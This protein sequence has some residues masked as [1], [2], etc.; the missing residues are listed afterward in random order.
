MKKIF[1][2]LMT[3][4]VFIISCGEDTEPV[5]KALPTISVDNTTVTETD[6]DKTATITLTLSEAAEGNIVFN[7]STI[8]GTAASGIDFVGV[9]DETFVLNPGNTT[10]TIEIRIKGDEV[11]ESNE[12]FDIAFLNPVGATFSTSR[13]TVTIA[14]DDVDGGITIPTTGY[15]SPLTHAG[16]TLVWQDE[17]DGNSLGSHWQQEIGT[18]N[19]G[20]G[21]N[22]LQ[23][24]RAEN[25]TVSDGN[26]IIEAKNE[27]FGGAAYTSSRMI[28]KGQ[29]FFKYGRVDIRAALPEGQGMWPALWMLGENIDQVGWPKC[30]EIDIMEVVGHQPNRTHGTLHWYSTEWVNYGGSIGSSTD[31]SEEFNVYSIIWDATEI[32]WLLNGIQFHN[33]DITPAELAEF[34]EEFFFI[35]NV[36]V[37]GNWPGSPNA[38]TVF[39]QRMYVDY[40]RVF[41]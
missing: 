7:Y 32:K 33:T 34:R 25:T 24:Y 27:S 21:N 16:Y 1:F 5:E 37:G 26:L 29:K 30:G 9:A 2:L 40:I 39:P 38:T 17:F 3:F 12:T 41:Q 19:S 14:D 28:T 18:G 8:A 20:W 6:V 22:E 31:L 13:I 4:T 23:Y 11:E 15:V 36:A 35:F 10:A